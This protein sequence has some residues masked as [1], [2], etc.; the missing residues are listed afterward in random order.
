[1]EPGG[2]FHIALGQQTAWIMGQY[3]VQTALK[4]VRDLVGTRDLHK[5]FKR[6]GDPVKGDFGVHHHWGYNFPKDN[7]GKSSAGC[8][9][10]RTETGHNEFINILKHDERY[11]QD[12]DF[13][14]TSTVLEVDDVLKN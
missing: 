10:G 2:A 1:M 4:Q 12:H 5:D 13:V 9:V 3:H 8:Q 6:Q 14:W 11:I 7:A